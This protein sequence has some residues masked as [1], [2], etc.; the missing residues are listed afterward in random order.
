MGWSRQA[1]NFTHAYVAVTSHDKSWILCLAFFILFFFQE[2][3]SQANRS[4]LRLWVSTMHTPSSDEVIIETFNFGR[5]VGMGKNYAGQCLQ[6]GSILHHCSIALEENERGSNGKQAVTFSKESRASLPWRKHESNVL[7]DHLVLHVCPTQDYCCFS[8]LPTAED[9][10]CG[11]SELVKSCAIVHKP[12]VMHAVGNF[13]RQWFCAICASLAHCQE[14]I[15]HS[16]TT[17]YN[18]IK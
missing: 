3:S 18:R 13:Q 2:D 11:C 6:T 4:V 12:K 17:P 7:T 15:L 9:G 16:P 5:H 10:K 14:R 8:W 1:F